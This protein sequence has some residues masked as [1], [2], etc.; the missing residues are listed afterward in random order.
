MLIFADEKSY[1]SWKR[2]NSMKHEKDRVSYRKAD[3]TRFFGPRHANS[4][5][6]TERDW[7]YPDE[8][9]KILNRD[10]GWRAD[11]Y[12]RFGCVQDEFEYY[13]QLAEDAWQEEYQVYYDKMCELD[14]L[15]AEK[16]AAEEK[17]ILEEE[18]AMWRKM[19]PV[20]TFVC[21][22]EDLVEE[23]Y[24]FYPPVFDLKKK[25]VF[26]FITN[27]KEE[28]FISL[29]ETY[30]FQINLMPESFALGVSVSLK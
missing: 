9:D 22:V 16:K 1:L 17:R 3:G 13:K 25:R 4:F 5:K 21:D 14:H 2:E 26:F 27:S 8:V 18:T 11:K 24:P 29:A 10:F 15:A 12:E 19:Y 6:P 30:G 20:E 23:I 28:R 7:G